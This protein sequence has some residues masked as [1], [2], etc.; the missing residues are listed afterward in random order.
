MNKVAIKFR[1]KLG[2]VVEK[3]EEEQVGIRPLAEL[4]VR[5]Y[6]RRLVQLEANHVNTDS[7]QQEGEKLL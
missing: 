4:L 1:K 6:K 5:W 7:G 3:I 2:P